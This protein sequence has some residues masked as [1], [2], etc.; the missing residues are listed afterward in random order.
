MASYIDFE[1]VLRSQGV[2]KI[3]EFTTHAGQPANRKVEV[4]NEF[5]RNNPNLTSQI[6]EDLA[7]RFESYEPRLIV[8]IPR[9]GELVG[10]EVAR[11]LGKSYL[12]LAKGNGDGYRFNCNGDRG[13]VEA[14]GSIGLIDDVMTT[15]SSFREVSS[16][17]VFK[18][19]IVVGGVI[20]DRSSPELKPGLDFDVLS[21]VK[22]YVPLNT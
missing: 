15:G 2:I 12:A 4:G 18:D 5:Q 1:G 16:L 17:P 3:G 9:G 11:H 21:V 14:M 22:N 8:G 6:A 20:W 19:R 7:E 13:V 10:I